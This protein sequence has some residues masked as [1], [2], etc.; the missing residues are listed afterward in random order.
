MTTRGE[1]YEQRGETWVLRI[2]L[3]LALLST[4]AVVVTDIATVYGDDTPPSWT[5]SP[6]RELQTEPYR[7][8]GPAPEDAPQRLLRTDPGG[9]LGVPMTF[10]RDG[11]TLIARGRIDRGTVQRFENAL[12]R[13]S[14][15]VTTVRLDS[16]GGSVTDALNLAERIR[17]AKLHT[18]VDAKD[19]CA[20]S[21]PLV[22]AGGVERRVHRAATVG[23]HQVYTE[24]GVLADLSDG[25]AHAQRISAICQKALERFGVDPLLWVEAMQTPRDQ[26]Y[27]L[28]PDEMR[29]YALATALSGP[30]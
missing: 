24:R 17:E 28:S 11:D 8:D 2:L 13:H 7:P 4:G 25:M 20:S 6:E 15:R 10:E 29:R 3:T 18:L 9:Q 14:E 23:V 21:C 12:L 16:P 27:V 1:L 19:Y 5:V 22:L 30:S 26:L